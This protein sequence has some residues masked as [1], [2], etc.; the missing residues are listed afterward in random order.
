MTNKPLRNPTDLQVHTAFLWAPLV[1]YNDNSNFY[2]TWYH[3]NIIKHIINNKLKGL[4]YRRPLHHQ[5]LLHSIAAVEPE[6]C[7]LVMKDAATEQMIILSNLRSSTDEVRQ[8]GIPTI[9]N[10]RAVELPGCQTSVQVPI[11]YDYLL[12]SYIISYIY[13]LS[14]NIQHDTNLNVR[15]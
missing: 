12:M 11:G 10:F 9:L 13:Y 4:T 1:L 6:E 8:P 15:I 2:L 14:I 7:L 3:N 5:L